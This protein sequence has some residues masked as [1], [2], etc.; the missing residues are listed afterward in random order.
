MESSPPPPHLKL[1]VDNG[2]AAAP[3]GGAAARN[4]FARPI[5]ED[6]GLTAADLRI[7]YAPGR[8]GLILALLVA[9]GT[10]L[11]QM[12]ANLR[13]TPPSIL[14]WILT[15]LSGLLH[16]AFIGGLAGL[17]AMVLVHWIDP[18][19]A[20]SWPV[21]GRLRRYR[22]ALAQARRAGGDQAA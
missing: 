2:A 16:G 6:Y 4:G 7:W 14:D 18:L 10:A 12:L 20:R 15:A 22:E 11:M 1:A 21:Y 17:G 3:P 9:G 8:V 13:Y 5:P 19:I